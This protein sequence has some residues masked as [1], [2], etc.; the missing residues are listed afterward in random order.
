MERRL[1][2]DARGPAV[3][4][5]CLSEGRGQLLGRQLRHPQGRPASRGGQDLRELDDGAREHRDRQQLHRLHERHP[6]L[7]CVHGRGAEKRPGG[8]HA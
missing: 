6:R 2:P 8:R 1:A 4:G 7:R 5:L 3:G